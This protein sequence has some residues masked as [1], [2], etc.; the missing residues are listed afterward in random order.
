[1]TGDLRPLSLPYLSTSPFQAKFKPSSTVERHATGYTDPQARRATKI[2]Q[3]WSLY[4]LFTSRQLITHVKKDHLVPALPNLVNLKIMHDSSAMRLSRR[5]RITRNNGEQLLGDDAVSDNESVPKLS[6]RS[7]WRKGKR[8][9]AAIASSSSSSSASS[10]SILLAK[11][12]DDEQKEDEA[13]VLKIHD[14]NAQNNNERLATAPLATKG[15]ANLPPITLGSYVSA[16]SAMSTPLLPASGPATPSVITPGQNPGSS[17]SSS[18]NK[19]PQQGRPGGKLQQDDI[20]WP[21]AVGVMFV[22]FVL[23]SFGSY[24]PWLDLRCFRF[25]IRF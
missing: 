5:H 18:F 12:Q 3:T 24:Y 22:V 9:N 15:A 21:I 8:S 13:L 19:A 10:S 6:K 7:S 20:V 17:S 16:M 25:P 11:R 4:H 1:M 23:V 2:W 14:A